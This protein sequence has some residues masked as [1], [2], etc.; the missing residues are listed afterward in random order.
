ML[1]PLNHGF[2]K[3]HSCESQ[4]LITVQDL[5]NRKDKARTQID[6]GVL[7]FAR[8][9]DKVPHIRLMSKLRL[10]GIQ[11]EVAAWISSFLS[12][13]SQQVVVDGSTSDS[14]DV[15]SGIPQG[16]VMGPFLF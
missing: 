8:A 16:T 10:Y 15:K 4:L 2:R 12:Q 5:I 3:Q 7:D 13:R 9:F 11:G 6:V 1:T 14:A